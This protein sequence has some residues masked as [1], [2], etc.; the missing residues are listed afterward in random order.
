M[1]ICPPLET[2]RLILRPVMLD[3]APAIQRIF[4]Q[5]EIVRYLDANIPW[6]YPSDGAAHYL[7]EM[8]L[9]AIAGGTAWSWT[10]RPKTAPDSVRGLIDLRDDA[11]DN[12]GFW[13][14]PALQGRGLMTEAAEAVTDYWFEVLER[15]L[16]RV[17]KAVENGASRR[18]SQKQGMRCIAAVE[19]EYV[20]G[21]LPS[22]IWEITALE[23]RTRRR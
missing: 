13:L 21:R 15:S 23:W 10:I 20:A 4:P 12:R 6:P 11:D 14:D 16:L 9:P 3:D 8:L 2:A 19:K 22:E 1:T 7:R 17:P 5:W 18:I